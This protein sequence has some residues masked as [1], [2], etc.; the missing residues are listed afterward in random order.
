MLF[1]QGFSRASFP[2]EDV[3]ATALAP[4]IVAL[5]RPQR[6]DVE[7]PYVPERVHLLQEGPT[8]PDLLND[9]GCEGLLVARQLPESA[10]GH[11]DHLVIDH[12]LLVGKDSRAIQQPHAIHDLRASYRR[13]SGY[14]RALDGRLW[15]GHHRSGSSTHARAWE[16]HVASHLARARAQY[17]RLHGTQVDRARLGVHSRKDGGVQNRGTRFVR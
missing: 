2:F 8:D 9:L 15:T 10:E 6:R 4:R 7:L 17:H 16:L 1:E 12:Q 14:D 11:T 13:Q 3:R 5:G